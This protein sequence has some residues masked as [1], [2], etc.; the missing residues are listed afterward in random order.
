M[1][2]LGMIHEDFARIISDSVEPGG[3]VDSWLTWKGSVKTLQGL[4]LTLLIGVG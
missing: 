3:W 1:V 4:P 2:N